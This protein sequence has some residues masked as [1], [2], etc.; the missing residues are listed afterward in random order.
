[1]VMVLLIQLVMVRALMVQLMPIYHANNL[2]VMVVIV[3]I[4]A[5]IV[6]EQILL[7]LNVGM[8]L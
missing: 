8:V 4:A 3:K 7:L 5:E 6:L 2:I 1:M